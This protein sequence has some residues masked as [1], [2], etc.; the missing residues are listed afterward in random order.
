MAV[1]TKT[2]RLAIMNLGRGTPLTLPVPD[3]SI[4]AFDRGHLAWLY[5]G[6]TALEI[7][8]LIGAVT[9]T[10]RLEGSISSSSRLIGTA[11]VN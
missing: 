6:Q 1:D 3:N 7:G 4:D 5:T 8:S 11:R 2:K 9:V 10:A